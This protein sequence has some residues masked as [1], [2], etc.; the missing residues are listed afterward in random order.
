MATG[1]E[2]LKVYN[3]AAKLE[4]DVFTLT[5]N[6]TTKTKKDKKRGG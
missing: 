1:L 6:L 4:L 5:K 2:N 3:M